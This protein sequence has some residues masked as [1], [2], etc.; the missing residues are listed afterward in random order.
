MGD[1]T[2]DEERPK[3]FTRDFAALLVAN[4][5]FGYAF[6]SFFLLPKFLVVALG[7]GPREIG[8]VAGLYGAAVV[9]SLPI[10]GAAVDRHGRRDYMTAGA[11][12]MAV[13]SLGFAA[14]D[15]VGPLLYALRAAQ[16]IAF[17]MAFAAGGALAVDLAPSGRLGQAIGIYG[18]SFLSMNAVAPAA[19]EWIA[20]HS[21]WTHA[22]ATAGALALVGAALSRRIRESGPPASDGS[23]GGGLLA[24]A[25]RPGQLLGLV[26]VG[27]VGAALNAV[28]SFHQPFALELGIERVSDFFVA[29]SLAAVTV[30]TGFGHLIDRWGHRPVSVGALSFYVVAV[31]LV[32]RLDAIPLPLLGLGM[33]LAHGVF[34]PSFNAVAVAGVGVAERGRVMALFQAAFQVGMA[35]G[36][37]GFGLLAARAG[38]PT[39]FV[40]ASAGLVVAL[41]LLLSG[42]RPARVATP[43]GPGDGE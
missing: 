39:V 28:F 10:M 1:A 34:F 11:L 42:P 2:I 40:A 8:T 22:F 6:S 17:A 31:L 5:C 24:V 15:S 20:A 36:G 14:V 41:G 18:L 13:A 33:G 4:V 29:Y 37:F 27:L 21:G 19:V 26:V 32:A 25:R 9:I 12:V 30:R 23:A 16:G 7:G 38:Y 43:P 35:V 3:L